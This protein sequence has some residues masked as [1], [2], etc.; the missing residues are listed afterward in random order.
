MLFEMEECLADKNW[1]HFYKFKN[2]SYK[3]NVDPKSS[4]KKNQFKK[5]MK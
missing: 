2:W 1:S 5:K 4:Q 3:K